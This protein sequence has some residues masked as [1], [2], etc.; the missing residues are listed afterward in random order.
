MGDD[1]SIAPVDGGDAGFH[2]GHVLAQESEVLAHQRAAVEGFY[3][4]QLHQPPGKLQHLQGA[5]MLNQTAHVVGH[6]LFRADQDVDGNGFVGKQAL[7]GEVSRGAYPR[8]LGGSAKQRVGHLTGD[9]VD[10]VGVGHRD[11][12]VGVFAACLAQHDGVGA[13]TGHR[14]DIQLGV[15]LA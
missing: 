13:R 1:R 8:D 9:H 15:Q 5:G 7:A 14:A 3:R 11:Q 10:L 12:H 6:H 2:V 4:H